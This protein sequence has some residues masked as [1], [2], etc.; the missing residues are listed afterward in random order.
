MNLAT[1]PAKTLKSLFALSLFSLSIPFADAAD[2]TWTGR[3]DS[4]WENDSNWNTSSTPVEGDV[5][6]INSG[7]VD[8]TFDADF[9]LRSL[10][11]GGGVLNISDG[12][13]RANRTAS[14]DSP[15]NG[16][17]IQTGGTADIN[18]LELGS[19]VRSSGVYNVQGGELIIGRQ[20]NG[21]A[22][23]LGGNHDSNAGGTGT[24][25]VSGGSVRTRTGVKLGSAT[26]PGTGRFV[27]L[28]SDALGIALGSSNDGFD[29][30]WEQHSGSTLQVGIDA[31]GVTSIFL[32]DNNSDTP[33]G[34]SAVFENGSILDVG[35][36]GITEGGGTWT[37]MEVENGDI[38]DN[39]LAF[40]PGVDTD[41]WSFSIDNSGRN[42]RLLVTAAGDILP[43]GRPL[44]IGSTP[45][46]KMRYGMDYER[47]WFWS[48]NLDNGER[49]DVARWS[50]VDAD[51]DFIRVAMNSEYEL[52]EGEYNL[53]AYTD[54]IIPMMQEMQEA[55]PNIKFFASPRPLNEAYDNKKWE[56]TD[57]RWQPYPIWVTGAPTPISGNFDFDWEKCSEYIV[58]YLLLMKSYGFQISF[59]DVTNEWQSNGGGGR[60][61]Q[62]DMDNLTEYLTDTYFDAPWPHPELDANLLLEPEDIPEII[63]PSSWNYEQGRQWIRNLDN[64]DAA[65][66]SIAASHNTDRSG[67]AASFAQA[68]R[69]RLGS[70]VEVWNTETHG[71]KSTGGENET[72]SFYYY[73][74]AIRA[75]FGGINGW[76]AIGQTGQGHAYIINTGTPR[77]NVKYYIYS[78]L[79]STSNYGHAL[80]ILEEPDVFH[81][82]L[83]ED[84]DDIPRNVAAFIKGN[85]MTVWV[86]NENSS[87]VPLVIRPDGRTIVQSSVR[88]TR[89]TD[90]DDVEGFVTYENVL[91]DGSGFVSTIPGQSVCCFEIT[92][93]GE[94]F[95]AQ[96]IQAEDYSHSFGLGTEQSSDDDRT[97]NVAFISNDDFLRY[98]SVALAE[99]STMSFRVARPTGRANSKIEIREGSYDGPVLGEVTVPVTGGWQDYS[100]IETQLDVDAGTYNLY[101]KFVE[102]G[103]AR[104]AALTNL[105]WF[106]INDEATTAPVPVTEL[107]ASAD[108][109]TG[110]TL[111]WNA[112][113]DADN[114]RVSRSLTP[115]GSFAGVALV[116]GTTFTDAGLNPFTTYYYLVNGNFDGETGPDSSVASARTSGEPIIDEN[117]E[118]STFEIGLDSSDNLQMSFSVEQT[119][120]GQLYQLYRS[121]T[122]LD[123]WVPMGEP[124]QGNGGPLQM[125]VPFDLASPDTPNEF[126]RIGVTVQ[127]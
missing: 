25:V 38:E 59:L 28:G 124:F 14:A 54:K 92:L 99:D 2:V 86:V 37:V 50:V 6:I 119:G 108:S 56:G 89:W 55:N 105:N 41:I 58:K 74:E 23:Y 64:G 62:D 69:D 1:S 126:F 82:P 100:T 18:E 79:A 93:D 10:R 70:D 15:V 5:A 57:V 113:E 27:V 36:F 44:V 94:D 32:D 51:T 83:G 72:T 22:L 29:A 60:L 98:G 34:A 107:V 87:A 33:A 52:V 61:T 102:V 81:A 76:L 24:F 43:Q 90:P 71:W 11:M 114:Y 73:L 109:A 39:G 96:K 118:I 75:G 78:K 31:G 21:F 84:D 19:A 97:E 88:R 48:G 26:Q 16:S 104:G 115:N 12:F 120:V 17:V 103:G 3:S 122:M 49:D 85:L 123:D 45:Q 110:I 63:A 7:A 121:R 111:D 40:A 91:E 66:I 117:M 67:D 77:R 125:A 101:L 9:G 8:Y 65:A 95:A 13:L 30:R 46:Q 42:G 127:E 116:T 47:L 4:D 53:R 20:L 106:T 68:A 112:A 35:Y 80:N